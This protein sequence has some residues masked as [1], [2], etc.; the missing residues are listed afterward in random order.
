MSAK[1]LDFT[2]KRPVRR[3]S[4]GDIMPS[5]NSKVKALCSCHPSR[6][7]RAETLVRG[8]RRAEMRLKSGETSS[9]TGVRGRDFQRQKRRKPAQCRAERNAPKRLIHRPV[10]A[11]SWMRSA[12]IARQ[13]LPPSENTSH[14]WLLGEG[15]VIESRSRIMYRIWNRLLADPSIGFWRLS[16][17]SVW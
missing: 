10:M 9:C 4:H 8:L 16:F 3:W 5:N 12:V 17:G 13:S 2:S 11:G 15:Q 6:H 1:H 7:G 14:G